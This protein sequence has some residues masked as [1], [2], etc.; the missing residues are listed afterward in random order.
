MVENIEFRVR[1]KS[2][3]STSFLTWRTSSVSSALQLL[4]WIVKQHDECI[5][6]RRPELPSYH[7]I[8][9]SLCE[10]FRTPGFVRRKSITIF[11]SLAYR[12]MVL[13]FLLIVFRCT[14]NGAVFMC[15]LRWSTDPSVLQ[16]FSYQ[17]LSST[18]FERALLTNRIRRETEANFFPII[19][20][21]RR[22]T[23]STR[24]PSA[25]K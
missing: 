14:Y 3:V 9:L 24:P 15:F 16:L 2:R 6:L 11:I 8:I 10:K 25:R 4:R 5:C 18:R 1:F 21:A 17:A 13:N 22:W 12:I 20:P 7:F 19:E 23:N